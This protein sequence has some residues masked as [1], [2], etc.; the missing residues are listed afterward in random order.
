M[1]SFL[2]LVILSEQKKYYFYD[3]AKFNLLGFFMPF[4]AKLTFYWEDE[5]MK[6]LDKEKKQQ[7]KPQKETK[8]KKKY[9]KPHIVDKKI[10][11]TL[12]G[13]C[14]L[15]PE[16]GAQGGITASQNFE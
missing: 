14:N 1:S 4:N 12:A 9:Q 2:K 8:P 5:A 16:C 11:E 3:E 15:G 6:N 10:I 13:S 7:L